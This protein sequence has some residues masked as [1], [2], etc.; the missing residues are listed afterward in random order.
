[1]FRMPLHSTIECTSRPVDRFHETIL[2][3]RHRIQPL[4]QLADGLMMPAV[5]RKVGVV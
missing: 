5:D 2:A 3:D 4:A 1:M